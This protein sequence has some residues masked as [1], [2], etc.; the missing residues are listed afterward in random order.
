[1]FQ[2]QPTPFASSSFASYGLASDLDFGF[3]VSAGGGGAGFYN[4]P[5]PP[6]PSS[7]LPQS[8]HALQ[9]QTQQQQQPCLVQ[10]QQI[11]R[12]QQLSSSPT[13][14]A[15][16]VSSPYSSSQNS[17]SNKTSSS[18]PTL[19]QPPQSHRHQQQQLD[20]LQQ[21]QYAAQSPVVLKMEDQGQ[22][23]MAA[24]QAAAEDYQPVLEGLAVG[25]KVSSDVITHEYAKADPVY[26]EK[27]ISLPQTYS[28]F[29]PI[30]GDGNCG[31]RAIGFSYFE[32]LV[33]S[34][35][36][37][38]IEGEVARLMS[39][40]HLLGSVG[41][42]PFYDDWS[43]EMFDFLRE[44]AQNVANPQY[45]H[46][47]IQ[48]KWNDPVVSSNI[49][50][51]LR[52][53]T[54]T[55]LKLNAAKFNPFVSDAGGVD[56]HCRQV[57]EIP[58]REIEHLGMSALAEVL[59]RPANFVLEIAYLDRSA[60][61]Q[62]NQYRVPDELNTQD[63]STLGPIIYLLYR[64]D[65]YDIL[66]K[67]PTMQ[68][69]RVSGF[70]HNTNI[71]TDQ[72]DLGQYS[73]MNFDALSIIPGFS[74]TMGGLAQLAPPPASSAPEQ[75]SPVQQSPWMSSFPEPLPATTPGVAPPQPPP[76]MASPQ[77]PTPP[78]SI[79][80]SSAIAPSP[81]M[82]P[83]SGP[84][85]QNSLSMRGASSYHIR[86]SPVQLDYDEGKN[87][88]PESTYQ[89]TTNT[90]KNS[91]WNRAHYCN[92]NF[93]PEEWNPD[94]EHTDGRVGNKRKPKKEAA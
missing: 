77:P 20:I 28:Q 25:N 39:M 30:Q 41:G 74:N 80:G 24:Q 44:V 14:T 34:G 13:A 55:Y 76:I 82:L 60:G 52:L 67:A 51:Y 22:H 71:T 8:S 90:F 36:Q 62:V 1:M 45:A 65:H 89:V 61:T 7:Q 48:A 5:P 79:S 33:E 42:Y 93:H 78:A 91:I 73:T 94:D 68:V 75:F 47:L 38:K 32:K 69:L 92:P 2:P 70:T 53:L 18:S 12:Q 59:L 35:D 84:G 88:F 10:Q 81:A 72:A 11:P 40:N 66:Y 16:S 21:T 26:V 17:T 58:N 50:Y 87:N 29:R 27:T 64:P 15:P 19:A 63:A 46:S 37:A 31:W 9:S 49:I 54:A 43:D 3:P 83:A 4:N 85:S 86:F 6:A 57:V 56:A 23:D